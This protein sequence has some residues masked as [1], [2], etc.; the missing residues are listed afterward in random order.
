MTWIC[1]IGIELNA[2]TQRWLLSAEIVA[3]AIF[4]VV[5]LV[6]VYADAPDEAIKPAL[7]WFSPFAI[8]S[9]DALIDGVL[10]GIFIYWG[11]DSLV[12]VNEETEDSDTVP[13]KAAVT[14]TV[15]LL[16]IYVIVSTAAIAYGGPERLANDEPAT[17]SACSPTTSS[18]ATGSARS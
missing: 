10:I 6:R 15:I 17:C 16:G 9:W 12:T 3:L 14:A 18:A 5:A 8:G 4:A 1:F 11:W 7:S 2:K 13:G